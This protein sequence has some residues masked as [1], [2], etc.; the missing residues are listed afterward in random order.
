[1][2]TRSDQVE[3][4]R[5]A[6]GR[7]RLAEPDAEWAGLFESAQR[8]LAS[9]SGGA[10]KN[11]AHFGSTAVPGL[12][13]KPI[14]DIMASVDALSAVDAMMPALRSLGYEPAEVGFLKRRFLRKQMTSNGVVYHLHVITDAAWPD[15]NEL[16]VRDWLIAHPDVAARYEALKEALARDHAD[17]MPAYTAAKSDF[18]RNVVNDVRR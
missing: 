6:L 7:V 18:L 4:A 3:L 1:M 11:I 16:L 10:F 17:D 8:R 12:R 14:I 5:S 2:N 15:K 9:I 13:A